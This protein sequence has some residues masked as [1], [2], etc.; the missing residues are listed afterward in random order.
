MQG[1]K[2]TVCV[3]CELPVYEYVNTNYRKKY[4]SQHKPITKSGKIS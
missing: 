1:K 3:F 4:I 2:Y